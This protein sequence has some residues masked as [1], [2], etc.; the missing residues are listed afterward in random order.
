MRRLGF[1][2]ARGLSAA[3]LVGALAVSV[4]AEPKEARPIRGPRE[5]VDPITRIVKGV[6]RSLG[7]LLVIPTP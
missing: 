6:I 4:S 3:V 2:V 1:F 7:D 5:R